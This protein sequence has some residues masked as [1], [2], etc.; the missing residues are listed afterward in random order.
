[1]ADK[2]LAWELGIRLN[3][4][5]AHMRHI[6]VKLQTHLNRSSVSRMDIA[7][8]AIS[9]GYADLA[10]VLSKY[11]RAGERLECSPT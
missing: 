6:S 5:K 9:N 2:E 10:R 4:V 11:Q 7:F 8:F 3:T 1:M